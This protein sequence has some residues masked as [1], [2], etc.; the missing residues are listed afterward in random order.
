MRI[1]P[2]NDVMFN[3]QSTIVAGRTGGFPAPPEFVVNAVAW[4]VNVCMSDNY[5]CGSELN[6]APSPG[7]EPGHTSRPSDT[8][9]TPTA[10]LGAVFAS[11]TLL[12]SACSSDDD[13]TSAARGFGGG[14]RG[15]TPVITTT[16]VARPMI[17]EIE[18]L[19]TA[20]ANESVEIRPRLA[21]LVTRIAFEEGDT[22]AAG[23]LLIELE[24]SEVRANL[25]V[26]EAALSE[27]R[28]LYERSMSLIE[29]QAIS[30]ANLEQLRAA[31]Q[32]D[33]A[34]VEAAR[35]RLANTVIR[36][37]FTG[38]VGLRRISPGSFVDTATILTTL[39]D[40]DTI[41]LDFT[42]P[43]TFLAVVHEDMDIVANSLVYP[44]RD[45]QGRV[46]S[47]DTRLD[48]VSRSVQVRAVLPNPE[49]LL[50]PGMFLT[51]DLQ[52]DRGRMVVAPEEAIVPEGREQFVFVVRDG[53]ARKQR[54]VLG[55]RIPGA[56]VILEGA[57]AGDE[58]VTEGTQKIRDGSPVDALNQAVSSLERT[59]GIATL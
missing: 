18:A 12:I 27:S 1:S 31:M 54:V 8:S 34:T 13:S 30:E 6:L 52:R 14:A 33:E 57:S 56:V 47:V 22:V 10:K 28:S 59:S 17:D 16:L 53:V 51:V 58:V 25:A 35:A 4:I 36:A 11:V 46:D 37:P 40:T 29:T 41:K 43:E 50:K 24:N 42:I 49:N 32:V 2:A 21:S 48:P 7:S 20:R 19:G 9:M 38:R 5:C 39:D 3:G 23:D 15:P 26:A 44:G 45:F 55:Q